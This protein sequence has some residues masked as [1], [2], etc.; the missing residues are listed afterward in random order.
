MEE[1]EFGLE[2]GIKSSVLAIL[3]LRYLLDLPMEVVSRNQ[4]SQAYR[5]YLSCWDWVTTPRETM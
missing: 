5:Q 4:E 3:S 2:R 1:E